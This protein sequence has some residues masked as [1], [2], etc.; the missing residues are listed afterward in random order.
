M[1]AEATLDKITKNL[2]VR[3]MQPFAMSCCH[4]MEEEGSL[5]MVNNQMQK[6]Q[7]QKTITIIKEERINLMIVRIKFG[8]SFVLCVTKVWPPCE[9]VHMLQNQILLCVATLPLRCEVAELTF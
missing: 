7:T 4:H 6:K 2:R 1:Q 8:A 5:V 3:V 9:S